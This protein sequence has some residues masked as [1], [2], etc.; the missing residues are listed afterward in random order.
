MRSDRE[1]KIAIAATVMFAATAPAKE[2]K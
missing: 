1:M 2:D